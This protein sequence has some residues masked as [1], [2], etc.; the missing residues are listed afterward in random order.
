MNE[1]RIISLAKSGDFNAVQ[2]LRNRETINFYMNKISGIKKQFPNIA[3]NKE[4][5][6]PEVFN[7]GKMRAYEEVV[8]MLQMVN[9]GFLKNMENEL[10]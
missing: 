7:L 10:I 5:T 8:L 2:Y 4:T 9:N 1:P 6:L 3:T